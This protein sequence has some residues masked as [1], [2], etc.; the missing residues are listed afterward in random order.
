MRRIRADLPNSCLRRCVTDPM[1]SLND[2]VPVFIK[3]NQSIMI[4]KLIVTN[5]EVTNAE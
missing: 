1:P 5:F 2:T 4:A 3:G